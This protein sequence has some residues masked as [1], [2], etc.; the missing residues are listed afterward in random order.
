M[1]KNSRRELYKLRE[2]AHFFMRGKTCYFCKKALSPAADAW[3]GYGDSV[4]P[5]LLEN[6]TFHHIDGDHS[7]KDPKNEA[8]CHTRCHKGWHRKV[9]NKVRELAKTVTVNSQ[10]E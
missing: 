6:I 9:A 5:K 4:G 1:T 8:P 2:I 3:T 7:N 10:G